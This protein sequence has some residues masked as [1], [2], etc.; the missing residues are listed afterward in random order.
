MD[1]MM[2]GNLSKMAAHIEKIDLRLAE[3][4]EKLDALIDIVDRRV[5]DDKRHT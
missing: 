3:T 4:A 2:A 5:W 1:K